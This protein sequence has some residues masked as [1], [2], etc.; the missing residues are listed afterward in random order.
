MVFKQ[1]RAGARR[2]YVDRMSSDYIR[3]VGS[4]LVRFVKPDVY[5]ISV[6]CVDSSHRSWRM[7]SGQHHTRKRVNFGKLS[8]QPLDNV[9]PKCYESA[10]LTELHIRSENRVL[11]GR[12]PLSVCNPSSYNLHMILA[13]G[14]GEKSI[15]RRIGA[16]GQVGG[17]MAGRGHPGA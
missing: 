12:D 17:L 10:P 11:P 16:A 5:V 8:D 3:F 6:R 9:R 1:V 13:A 2:V 7:S 15:S 4:D 14:L